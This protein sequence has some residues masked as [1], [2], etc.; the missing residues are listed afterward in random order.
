MRRLLPVL[1]LLHLM[2]G[3]LLISP[4]PVEAAD[5]CPGG[6]DGI[7]IFVFAPEG[8]KFKKPNLVLSRNSKLGIS[9]VIPKKIM[10]ADPKA[11]YFVDMAGHLDGWTNITAPSWSRLGGSDFAS[12]AIGY[13]AFEQN[14]TKI[15]IKEGQRHLELA[16]VKLTET[17]VVGIDELDN[18]PHDG[19]VVL[20]WNYGDFNETFRQALIS[21][22]G[23]G[24]REFDMRLILKKITNGTI[25]DVCEGP[26]RQVKALVT[27][28]PRVEACPLTM[29]SNYKSSDKITGSVTV[30]RVEDVEYRVVIYPA[31]KDIPTSPF[32]PAAGESGMEEFGQLKTDY[33][34]FTAHKDVVPGERGLYFG[35][36]TFK[37]GDVNF[38]FS[39]LPA[40]SYKIATNAYFFNQWF[41]CSARSFTVSENETT[42]PTT[43]G[44]STQIDTNIAKGVTQQEFGQFK[45]CKPENPNC[46]T[47][48]AQECKNGQPGIETAIG[49]VPT[50]PQKLIEGLLRF[51]TGIGGGIALLLMIFGAF[52]MIVS[53]G[54]PETLKKGQEQFTS[55]IIGLLFI[56]FSILLLQVIGVNILQIPGFS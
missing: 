2:L 56:I 11:K 21:N 7:S 36:N 15:E 16:T 53:S 4:T 3:G 10:T 19:Y 27:N 42:A 32:I 45:A 49:C 13:E 18:P 22:A 48:A 38:D 20:D 37:E 55:A 14:K 51:A 9:V 5:K 39:G 1:L 12:A 54:N 6:K 33:S 41:A 24:N 29:S 28:L 25:S 31:N 43:E 35:P 47:A 26:D 8:D 44:G 40:G 34:N 30:N 52:Q 50:E 17:P 23:V 46:T